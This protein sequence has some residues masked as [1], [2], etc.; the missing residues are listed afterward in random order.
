MAGVV[1]MLAL[2]VVGAWLSEPRE[3]VQDGRG[4]SLWLEDLVSPFGER[5]DPAR[6]AVLR[7]GTN[8]VPFLIRA[9]NT[10]D[11]AFG[12][13]ATESRKYL[14][15]Q[16]WVW[17]MQ[18][19]R[20]RA[21]IDR[22]WPAA[23]ALGVLGPAA[24]PAVPALG[25]AIR[26]R[27]PRVSAAA[28][29]A[30]RVVG[31]AGL[32]VVVEAMRTNDV[33]LL[34]HLAAAVARTGP[35]AAEWAPQLVEVL[36]AAPPACRLPV[37]HALQGLGGAAVPP[38]GAGLRSDQAEIRELAARTLRTLIADDHAALQ[39]VIRLSGGP[40]PVLRRGA[41]RAL[42]A[43]TLWQRG[44]I[45]AL[46][47]ALDDSES[48]VRRAALAALLEVAER[49]DRVTNALEVVRARAGS[50]IGPEQV[51]AQA[52]QRAIEAWLELGE[53]AP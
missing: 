26:D 30:L 53:G 13:A 11:P 21:G 46:T 27:D 2:L 51:E 3:P 41:V 19:A 52:V 40:D 20:P 6:Q 15:R 1:G 8:A 36:L 7:L 22:R 47:R 14:P 49:T 4:L 37:T 34:H 23:V 50:A 18:L 28:I 33:T 48:E 39:E 45:T 31:P 38:L 12:S 44:A 43:G 29:E 24:A 9:L 17:V 5:R 10:P 35:A 42:G 32:Q 16:L 25:H